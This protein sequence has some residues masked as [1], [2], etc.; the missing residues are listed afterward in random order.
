MK[1]IDT[2]HA[3]YEQWASRWQIVRAATDSEAAVKGLGEKVVPKL[4]GHEDKDY[5]VYLNAGVYANF[6]GRTLEGLIG[7]AFRKDA[8]AKYPDGFRSIYEDIDLKGNCTSNVADKALTEIMKTGNYGILVDHPNTPVGEQITQAQAEALSLRPFVTCYPRES[9]LDWRVERVNNV[10]QPVMIKLMEHVQE[11]ESDFTSK[12]IEQIRALLLL[13]KV[14]YIQRLYRKNQKKEW[15]QYQDD[16]IPLMNNQPMS[17]IPFWMLG[18]EAN[19]FEFACPFL[20]DMASLNIAHFRNSCSYERGLI[21]TGAPTPMLA[22]FNMAENEKLMLGST[23]AMVTDNDQAK[24]GF[25]EFTGAGLATI[26]GAMRS[27]ESQMAALGARMLAP[28][29]TGVEAEGTLKMRTNGESSALAKLVKSVSESMEQ[30]LQFM[31]MWAGIQTE[32]EYHLN[33]DFNPHG[34]SG[35]DLK[36]L[37]NAWLSGAITQEELFENLQRGEIIKADKSFDD[38]REELQANPPL[39]TMTN[40]GQ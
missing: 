23:K 24:W 39:G 10:M 26:E 27:K 31:A 8:H 20:E 32:I 3:G 25:L 18:A 28:E 11:W 40:D 17:Q 16:I 29:K 38:H 34:L 1:D 4:P 9:I 12:H 37:V 14:G 21:Y 19:D 15:E 22:G 6:T 35:S 2:K 36:E 30:I 5:K 13:P 7:M 33:T